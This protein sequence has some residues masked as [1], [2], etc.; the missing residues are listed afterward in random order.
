[1]ALTPVTDLVIV[2]APPLV[3]GRA[4]L[5]TVTASGGVTSR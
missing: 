5:D 4:D 1:M 2:N 3:T